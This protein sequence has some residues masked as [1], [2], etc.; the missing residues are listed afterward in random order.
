MSKNICRYDFPG[1]GNLFPDLS[2]GQTKN[3]HRR[4]G[5]SLR[6]DGKDSQLAGA[7]IRLTAQFPHIFTTLSRTH[8]FCFPKTTLGTSA[9]GTF[10]HRDA[11]TLGYCNAKG[12]A[13]GLQTLGP[14][15]SGPVARRRYSLTHVARILSILRTQL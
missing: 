10:L 14:S 12:N 13:R 9:T 3:T 4:P 7:P 1:P 15:L 8:I 6:G 2:T 11:V 5:R